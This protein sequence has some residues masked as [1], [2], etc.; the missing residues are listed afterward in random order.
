[1]NMAQAPRAAVAAGRLPDS[2]AEELPSATTI[3]GSEDEL[4]SLSLSCQNG[5]RVD[6]ESNPKDSNFTRVC[7]TKSRR[8]VSNFTMPFPLDRKQK[9]KL[10]SAGRGHFTMQF[11]LREANRKVQS[12][13]RKKDLEIFL[14]SIL[15]FTMCV[16]SKGKYTI[17]FVFRRI[18]ALYFL[19]VLRGIIP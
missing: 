2:L 5:R 13:R 6:L 16:R 15:D 1:M 14:R 3:S 8:K 11:P 17:K 19:S 9:V 4:L 18:L 12:V 7:F 10:P